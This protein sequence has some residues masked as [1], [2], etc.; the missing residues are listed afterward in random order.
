MRRLR[1]MVAAVLA[2]GA[3]AAVGLVLGP[4]WGLTVG[5]VLVSWIAICILLIGDHTCR[6]RSQTQTDELPSSDAIR[7]DCVCAPSKSVAEGSSPT[8]AD[9][10]AAPTIPQNT[11]APISQQPKPATE[12]ESDISPLADHEADSPTTDDE[13]CLDAHSPTDDA[14]THNEETSHETHE[15]EN[16]PQPS[17]AFSFEGF[18]KK[19]L[20]SSKPMIELC[21]FCRRTAQN[22]DASSLEKYLVRRLGEAHIDSWENESDAPKVDL[23]IP[24]HSGMFYLREER[25]IPLGF[26]LRVLRIEAALNAALSAYNHFDGDLPSSEEDIMRFEQRLASTICSQLSDVTASDWSY[27]AMPWQLGPGPSQRGEWAVRSA[28][29]ESIE[30]L[31][32]PYRLEANF[33]TNV[34]GGDAAI[35]VCMT[36]ARVFPRSGYVENLGIVPTTSHM[37]NRYASAYAARVGILLA[38]CA[39]QASERVRRAWVACIQATPTKRSCLYWACIERRGLSRVRMDAVHDPLRLLVSLGATLELENEVLQPVPQGFYLE[40][41]RFCPPLRHDL[42]RLSERPLPPSAAISLGTQRVSGLSI[43]EELGRT[44]LAEEALRGLSADDEKDATQLCVRSLFDA[45]S[46]T[47]DLDV[48]QAAERVA[49][50]LIAGTLTPGNHDALKEELV[51]G[52]HLS[53]AVKQAQKA[54]AHERPGE[55]L[56]L[57]RKTIRSIDAHNTY[58]DTESAV[59]RAFDSF[60]QRAIYNRLN[61]QDGRCV[62]LVPDAYVIAHLIL[63]TLLLSRAKAREDEKREVDMHEALAHAQRALEVAP[64]SMPAVL[65]AVACL[66][67]LDDAAA[68]STII[69]RMLEFAHDPQSIALAYYRMASMQWQLDHHE[70]CLACYQLAAGFSPGYIPVITAECSVL[71]TQDPRLAT[72]LEAADVKRALQKEGIPL[73]PTAQI[74]YLLYDCAAASIDAE[75][76]PVADDLMRI[77]ESFTGDDV[78]HGI[79]NSLEHEPDV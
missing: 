64:F 65:S 22:K 76:F 52:D 46:K 34:A 28:L 54:L 43:H 1:I 79:R 59:Y 71:S 14:A 15:E 4:R 16:D 8:E 7:Y 51:S 48:W 20:L 56:E 9:Q 33:R 38:N 75:V 2:L 6:N 69:S 31:Q 26:H 50:Q 45:A 29:S 37:R 13:P 39:F 67:L 66:E 63:T 35:E 73:A 27:L 60:A 62:I 19:L 74:S 70:A 53:K 78:L 41:N 24:H 40:D 61:A 5:F 49:S 55:A 23:V 3:A 57:L 11:Q 12:S 77:L 30:T 10:P 21:E 44:L 68:A 18:A 17:K 42:W 47:S 32:V 36:P 72:P 58:T 25:R